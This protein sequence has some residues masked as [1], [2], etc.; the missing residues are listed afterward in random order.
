M[1]MGK[2]APGTDRSTG[3]ECPYEGAILPNWEM[4]TRRQHPIDMINTPLQHLQLFLKTMHQTADFWSLHVGRPGFTDQPEMDVNL[5]LRLSRTP[6][7]PEPEEEQ[8]EAKKRRLARR[9]EEFLRCLTIEQGDLDKHFSPTGKTAHPKA[10]LL[11]AFLSGNLW[12]IEL[13][14]K[15]KLCLQDDC[16]LCKEAKGTF[17]HTTWTCHKLSPERNADERIRKYRI[18]PEHLPDALKKHGWAAKMSADPT[19]P[20]WGC[21]AKGVTEMLKIHEMEPFRLD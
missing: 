9:R 17:L 19:L 1:D 13:L 20:F 7:P 5:T 10:P 2:E 8:S 15:A 12:S 6:L 18:Y 11:R 14:H 3:P 21:N 16:F 4:V